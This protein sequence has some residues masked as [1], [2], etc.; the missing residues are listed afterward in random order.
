[1]DNDRPINMAPYMADVLDAGIPLLVYNG[2]RDMTT[3]MVGTEKVLNNM[4][5][6]GK[7]EWLDAPR[8]LWMTEDYESGWAKEY[9]GLF[10]VVVYNSGHMVP[11]NQ[12]VPAFDL[13]TRFLRG[14]SFI[15]NELPQLRVKHDKT[16]AFSMA[17]S[18]IPIASS[19]INTV[20]H[21]IESMAV[22]ALIA[23]L[24]GIVVSLLFVRGSRNAGYQRVP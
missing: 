19:S 9:N 18:V 10:F 8:G 13:L 20:N 22:V 1:M 23:F 3:N 12:P 21:G 24:A 2:D 11:Y 5:W 14:E 6:N 17:D 4:D 16:V 7:K 15:D